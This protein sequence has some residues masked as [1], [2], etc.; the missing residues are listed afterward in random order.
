MYYPFQFERRNPECVLQALL[1]IEKFSK[2]KECKDALLE[3]FEMHRGEHPVIPLE[4]HY[5]SNDL[6]WRLIGFCARWILDNMC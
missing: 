1:A 4:Q 3:Y 2:T 6:N 5:D